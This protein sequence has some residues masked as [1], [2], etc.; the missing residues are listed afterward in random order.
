MSRGLPAQAEDRV[1][2]WVVAL[3]ILGRPMSDEALGVIVK[4]TADVPSEIFRPAMERLI[5]SEARVANPVAAFLSLVSAERRDRAARAQ[6]RP[7]A[8]SGAPIKP[9]DLRLMMEER[10]RRGEPFAAA[11]LRRGGSAALSSV[12]GGVP[13]PPKESEKR[14]EAKRL[15]H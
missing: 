1:A 4:A 10:A 14:D 5:R 9:E 7:S 13:A 3:E 8:S 2:L 11:W 15:G 6:A 12:L